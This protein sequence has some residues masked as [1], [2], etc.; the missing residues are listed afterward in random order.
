[1]RADR[2]APTTLDQNLAAIAAFNE[3]YLKAIDDEDIAALSAPTTDR[4]VM[5][6]PNRAPIAGGL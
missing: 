5:F 1:V 3:R 2:I 6:A 4:H